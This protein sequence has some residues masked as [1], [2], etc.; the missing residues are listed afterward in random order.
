MLTNVQ[1]YIRHILW[2]FIMQYLTRVNSFMMLLQQAALGKLFLTYI[3]I[4]MLYP[5]HIGVLYCLKGISLVR[6]MDRG[7]Q[8]VT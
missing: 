8:M 1:V 5:I 6:C 2:S 3:G 4:I 7:T